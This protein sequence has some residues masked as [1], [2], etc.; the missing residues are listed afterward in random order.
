MSH[1]EW[2]DQG[3]LVEKLIDKVHEL[4]VELTAYGYVLE[5]VVF[6]LLHDLEERRFVVERATLIPI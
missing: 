3:P 4:K 5:E 6:P 2:T 1:P